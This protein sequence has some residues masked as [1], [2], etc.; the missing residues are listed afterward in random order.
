MNFD[1]LSA[2]DSL[3]HRIDPR[4]RIAVCA[5]FI[6]LAAFCSTAQGLAGCLVFSLIVLS[7]AKL[8]LAD[9]YPRLIMLN[10]FVAMVGAS[11]PGREG[12]FAL[13][14]GLPDGAWLK[15]A[16]LALRCNAILIAATALAGT[17]ESSA[18]GHALAH[19]R[20]PDKLTHLFLFTVSQTA[21]MSREQER[22]R[23]AM[24]ARAFRPRTDFHSYRSLANLAA[25]LIVRS[26]ERAAKLSEAMRCR[27]FKGRF[28]LFS[29]FKMRRADWAFAINSIIA[30]AALLALELECRKL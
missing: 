10:L 23:D 20:V 3:I 30:I 24:R 28:H 27:N 7:L 5:V 13:Y 19:F 1:G 8:S 11:M 16:V 25:M 29:H 17:I 4:A 22:L 21:T 26:L 6:L 18:F 9:I 14:G 12:L 15:L 2:R